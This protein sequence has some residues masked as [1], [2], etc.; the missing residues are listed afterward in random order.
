MAKSLSRS[1]DSTT[2]LEPIVLQYISLGGIFIL[3][4]VIKDWSLILIGC[5]LLALTLLVRGNRKRLEKDRSVRF[6]RLQE[7]ATQ[8]PEDAISLVLEFGENLPGHG[9]KLLERHWAA[10]HYIVGVTLANILEDNGQ[11][12][13][14]EAILSVAHDQGDGNA[15]F[16]LGMIEYDRKNFAEALVYFS[17]AERDGV[18]GASSWLRKVRKKTEG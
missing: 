9:V 16:N 2:S 1:R 4:V 7:N 15:S 10:Q 12:D 8:S 5:G 17:A 11:T 3:G 18:S 13:R 14:A 6:K